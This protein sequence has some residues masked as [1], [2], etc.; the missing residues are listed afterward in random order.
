M[1]LESLAQR[2]S[3][4]G[5]R[6]DFYSLFGERGDDT[7]CIGQTENGWEVYYSERGESSNLRFFT[8]EEEACEYFL[9]L[10]TSDSVVMN[11]LEGAER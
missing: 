5:I 1:N 10:I 3:D 4:M 11:N 7:F 8:E 6:K 2:L 9:R